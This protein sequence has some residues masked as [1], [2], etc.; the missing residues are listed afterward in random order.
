MLRRTMLAG[1]ASFTVLGAC[2]SGSG[3]KGPVSGVQRDVVDVVGRDPELGSFRQWIQAADYAD[4]LKRRGPFTLFAPNDRAI[5]SLRQ[6]IRG[7]LL[8]LENRDMLRAVLDHHVVAGYVTNDQLVMVRR[9]RTIDGAEVTI[10]RQ[11]EYLRFGTGSLLRTNLAA[12]NGLIHVIS[13][14]QFP[15]NL[16]PI[17]NK[18]DFTPK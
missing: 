3:S 18:P 15:P 12:S 2:S 13:E 6:G 14:V 8:R 4:R 7:R 11:G 16:S 1:L 9:F 10:T 5:G 17:L